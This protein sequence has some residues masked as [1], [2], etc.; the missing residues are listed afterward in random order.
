LIEWKLDMPITVTASEALANRTENTFRQALARPFYRRLYMGSAPTRGGK[1]DESKLDQPQAYLV[2][3]PENS[4]VSAHFHDTNQFQ[5]FVHGGG[6]FGKKPVDGMVVHY[7]GAHTPY[8]PIEAGPKGAHYMTLRNKWDS[9]AKV[10]PENRNKLRK[11]KRMHRIAESV[12][13]PDATARQAIKTEV[14]DLVP[15]EEDGLGVRQFDIGPDRGFTVAFDSLGAGA[16]AFVAGGS[17]SHD[18]NALET[19]SLL[20]LAVEEAP[21]MLTA[22]DQGTSVLLLQFPPEPD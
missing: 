10:M 20:Y 22:G 15:L 4:T 12:S 5:I 18:G 16:Y 13:I 7:A 2:E 21:L 19:H 9:G 14:T 17:V 8:G 3:Q 6:Y 1:V 11:I